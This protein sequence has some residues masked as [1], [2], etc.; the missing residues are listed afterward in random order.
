M[1]DCSEYGITI[2]GATNHPTIMDKA[3]II[4][5][6]RFTMKH[7]LE[8]PSKEDIKDILE[9]YLEGLKDKSVNSDAIAEKLNTDAK[10]HNRAYSC[11]GIETLVEKAKALAFEEGR[12]VSQKDLLDALEEKGS[13]IPEDELIRFKKDYET[14]A[15]KSYEEDTAKK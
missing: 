5:D 6:K 2:V 10:K 1:K 15:G 12:F 4:N 7:L 9:Y 8:P 14:I 3:F 13:D 11:S